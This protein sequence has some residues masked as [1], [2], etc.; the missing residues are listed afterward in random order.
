M[1][2]NPPNSPAPKEPNASRNWAL[3]GPLL[4]DLATRYF[5][6]EIRELRGVFSVFCCDDIGGN[7]VCSGDGT[8]ITEAIANAWTDSRKEK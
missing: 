7:V 8:R 5:S 3:T 1:K 6:V 4:R 2:Q